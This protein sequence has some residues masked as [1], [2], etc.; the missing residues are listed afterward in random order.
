MNK[1]N[2][3]WVFNGNNA[4]FPSG[5]FDSVLNAEVW[6]ERYS[7]T[8]ILTFY[9]LNIS[10]YEWHIQNGWFIPS[11]EHHNTAEFIEKFSGGQYHFHYENGKKD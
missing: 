8:G 7:L 10:V 5:V 6:I 9:P 11:K 1:T 4:R 3:V 2:G